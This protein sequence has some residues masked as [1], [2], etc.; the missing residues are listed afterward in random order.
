MSGNFEKLEHELERE[1]DRL[2]DLL[3]AGQPDSE[4]VQRIQGAVVQEGRNLLRR[5]KRLLTMRTALGTAAA[6]IM[7]LFFAWPQNAP[8]STKKI[9]ANATFADWIIALDETDSRF[10][11]LLETDWITAIP[12]SEQDSK[13]MDGVIESLD[14]SMQSFESI[15]GT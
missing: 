15:M 4:L 10:E 13:T 7:I 2:S 6:L 12:G 3:D 5:R 14:E 1:V 9:A 8:Q 11:T